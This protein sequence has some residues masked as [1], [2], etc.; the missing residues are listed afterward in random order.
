MKYLPEYVTLHPGESKG[1][2]PILKHHFMKAY[3]RVELEFHYFFGT[4][5]R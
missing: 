1:K 2:T 4:R 5:W 3:W